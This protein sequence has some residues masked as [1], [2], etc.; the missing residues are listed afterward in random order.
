MKKLIFRG[1]FL[2][3]VGVVIFSCNKEDIQKNIKNETEQQVYQEKSLSFKKH[4]N[5]LTY[6]GKLK[7][8]TLTI[9]I[10]I[11]NNEKSVSFHELLEI[12]ISGED[13]ATDIAN[14]INERANNLAQRHSYSTM[15]SLSNLV[16]DMIS[17]EMTKM[18]DDEI[19]DMSSQ[20][21]FMCYSLIQTT[22]RIIK[23]NERKERS[24]SSIT[25]TPYEGFQLGLTP[26]LLN[27]DINI[28]V[29]NFIQFIDNNPDFSKE[30]GAYVFKE[31]L[32]T[33]N[34]TTIT[35]QRL[36]E[37]I[38]IYVEEQSKGQRA[39]SWW[40]SGS[41]HGCCGNYSGP[42]LYWHPLCY[43]HDVMC[44]NCEPDWFCLSG[45]VLQYLF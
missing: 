41:S 25:S 12:D 23:N 4:S 17:S 18:T 29:Q 36:F 3:L 28:N 37:E 43:V 15:D 35:A 14:S 6:F 26:F 22:K 11:N 40:P 38:D 9:D 27:E 16:M 32:E 33:I 34:E 2:A 13:Y 21:L 19:S 30:K 7:N 31:V 44:I 8:Q 39:A 10:T 1:L 45:C 24:G 5:E 42:C 20:G